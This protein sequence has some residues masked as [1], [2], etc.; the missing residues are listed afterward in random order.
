MAEAMRTQLISVFMRLKITYV[1]AVVRL[2]VRL[3]LSLTSHGT[4]RLSVALVAPSADR[5][6]DA[7]EKKASCN[8]AACGRCRATS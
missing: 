3:S 7:R 1:A 5:G 4:L 2:S 6:S 8:D